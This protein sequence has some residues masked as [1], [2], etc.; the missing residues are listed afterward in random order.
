MKKKLKKLQIKGFAAGFLTVAVVLMLLMTTNVL[1]NDFQVSNE[2]QLRNAILQAGN[3]PATITLTADI[4]L[5]STL[6]IPGGMDITLRSSDGNMF[7]LTRVA[8]GGIVIIIGSYGTLT[9]E[10]IEVMNRYEGRPRGS[11]IVNEGSLRTCIQ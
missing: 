11:L 4:E 10:N 6:V 1:G 9:I 7:S 2:S 3:T 8:E 5:N